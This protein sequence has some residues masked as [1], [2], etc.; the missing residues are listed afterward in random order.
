MANS[1]SIQVRRKDVPFDGKIVAYRRRRR[2]RRCRFGV[3]AR[4]ALHLEARVADT[5]M[6]SVLNGGEKE[7]K[8]KRKR[9]RTFLLAK[10]FLVIEWPF[11]SRPGY[12]D[13]ASIK[14]PQANDFRKIAK[15]TASRSGM[16]SQLGANH[17]GRA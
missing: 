3:I 15:L 2:D 11:I 13:K 12:F 1:T 7:K 16:S 10:T 5:N 6:H 4:L 14:M 8:R 9:D 17:R